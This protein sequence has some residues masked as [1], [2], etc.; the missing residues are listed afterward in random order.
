MM[1]KY[2][3][4]T[5]INPRS[6]FDLAETN[7]IQKN[8]KEI[9]EERFPDNTQ[10]FKALERLF[11]CKK[12]MVINETIVESDTPVKN[13]IKELMPEINKLYPEAIYITY[14]KVHTSK[15]VCL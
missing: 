14:R 3:V 15:L 5:W 7:A 4:Y 6:G 12:G 2:E 8:F 1:N 9:I 10:A 13:P 11:N